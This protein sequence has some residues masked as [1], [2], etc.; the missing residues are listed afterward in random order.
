MNYLNYLTAPKSLPRPVA[1]LVLLATLFVLC[2]SQQASAAAGDFDTTF[3]SSG[4]GYVPLHTDGTVGD[5]TATAVALQTDGK[6]VISLFWT[7][8]GGQTKIWLVRLNADGSFDSTF[9]SGGKAPA[10]LAVALVIQPDGKIVLVGKAENTAPAKPDFLLSRYNTDGS[11]DTTFGTGGK[12]RTDFLGRE[13]SPSAVILQPDEKIVVA[14]VAFTGDTSTGKEGSSFALAR[15]NPDGSLDT[16]F[17]TGG[18][19]LTNFPD[20][21]SLAHDVLFLPDWKLVVAGKTMSKIPNTIADDFALVRYNTDGSLDSTFGT[22]GRVTKDIK[23]TDDAYSLARQQDGRLLV[24]GTTADF[25]DHTSPNDAALL[26]YNTDGTLDTTFGTDGFTT[27]DFSKREE[28]FEKV[29]V[30]SDGK[31]IVFCDAYGATSGRGSLWVLARYQP[32][33]TLD[34]TFGQSGTKQIT[35]GYNGLDAVFQPDGK[36]VI[37]GGTTYLEF[38]TVGIAGRFLNDGGLPLPTPTP[39]PKP[40]LPLPTLQFTKASYTVSESAGS[41]NITVIRS[42]DLSVPISVKYAT[43]DPTDVNFK[44]DPYTPGQATIFASRKCDYHIAVGTLRFASGE[45]TKQF[46][47]SFT[48]DVYVE[49]SEAFSVTLSNPVGATLGENSTAAV[50]ITD[51]D[52]FGQPNPIDNTHFFVRQLYVDLL[53]REPDPAGWDGW[54]NRI[55]L[56]GLPGQPP[57]PC[58]RVTVAGDGFLRSGEFFDR[59]FFV[60][61]LYRTGLGRILRYEE[62]G[63]LAAV[64]GFLTAEQ[65]ELNKQDLVN[66]IVLRPEFA[67]KYNALNNT[68]F[69]LKLF[70]TS[71][72]TPPQAVQDEWINS[73]QNNTKSRAQVYREM[74]ERPEVSAKYLH[75]AQVVS[76]YYGFFTRNPDGAYLNYLQRLDAGE[77]TL[78]DLANAFINAAEYRSRFGQ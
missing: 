66:E 40:A 5:G 23:P 24:G 17:G 20:R 13:D 78:S 54:T 74:S 71:G 61:R 10:D 77:I 53:S 16:S 44:C 32:N 6:L 30:Q 11:L 41:L 34:Q 1:A 4:F 2:G 47:L 73:L 18:K 51:N 69:L 68:E 49:P 3:G 63:D 26:R 55:N 12:V 39:G 8:L 52:T 46:T 43:S 31:I 38:G 25:L 65:L 15:Y 19:V 35:N 64:S 22:S 21:F 28:R 33:G 48:D 14:G 36:I 57:P 72:V 58:D 60:I 7:P 75:E 67:G 42:G 56:C 9:G 70:E 76:A 62:I 27:L 37:I 50:T 29:F 45:T 59:Q